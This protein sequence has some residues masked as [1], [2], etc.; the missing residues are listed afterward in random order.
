MHICISQKDL[1]ST[2]PI[3]VIRVAKVNLF[4][5]K[6]K[7]VKLYKSMIS[8]KKEFENLFVY[9]FIYFTMF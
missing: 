3:A 6:S 5:E 8:N 7:F 2:T 1:S 4:W 9:L